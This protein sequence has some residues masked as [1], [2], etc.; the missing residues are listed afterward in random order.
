MSSNQEP[1]VESDRYYAV[2]NVIEMILTSTKEGKFN[3][4]YMQ[5]DDVLDFKNWWSNFNKKTTAP[6]E[7]TILRKGK[8]ILLSHH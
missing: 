4:G 5:I 1:H 2:K 3:A 6:K 8:W 7:T